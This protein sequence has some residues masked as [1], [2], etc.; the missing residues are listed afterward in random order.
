MTLQEHLTSLDACYYACEQACDFNSVEE[1]VST[2]D[3]NLRLRWSLWYLVRTGQMRAEQIEELRDILWNGHGER[4]LAHLRGEGETY[5]ELHIWH[6]ACRMDD[7]IRFL[8]EKDEDLT[9]LHEWLNEHY[10]TIETLW[11]YEDPEQE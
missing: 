1:L 9:P 8:W 11:N 3:P 10:N 4:A 7:L 2:K 5:G 6:A